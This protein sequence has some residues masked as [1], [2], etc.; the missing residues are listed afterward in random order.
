MKLWHDDVREPP[1]GWTWARTNEAARDYLAYGIVTECS[2]DHDM[3]LHDVIIPDPNVD[4]DGFMDAVYRK[5]DS[6]DTGYDLVNWMIENECVP[7]KV[8]IHSWN[9]EGAQAMAA[10]LNYFGYDCYIAP[11]V[12]PKGGNHW[13]SKSETSSG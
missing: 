9:P 1:E 12:V 10:R 11:Y 8:T 6:E 5:G 2:L 3:G 4:P 7:E 13:D